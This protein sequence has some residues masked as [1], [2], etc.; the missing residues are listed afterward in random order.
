MKSNDFYCMHSDMC[1]TLANEKRQMIID[2]LR[3][4]EMTVSELIDATGIM[5][6]NLSQHLAI[7]RAKGVVRTR[8]QG[9]H[10]YYC[11]ANP[12][13]LAAFDLI[14]EAMAEAFGEQKDMV[15]VAMSTDKQG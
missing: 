14:S 6:A 4:R 3:D 7:L 8:R 13:I 11:I 12:K 1:K 5:Q 10:V 2:T 9:T 15:D